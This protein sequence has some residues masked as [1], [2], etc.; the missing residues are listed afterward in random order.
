[1]AIMTATTPMW[2]YR[3]IALPRGTSREAARQ[4]LTGAA[5]TGHWELA[6]SRLFPDGRRAVRLRRRVYRVTRTA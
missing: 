5:D 1:M 4:L 2:E 6:T 3:D